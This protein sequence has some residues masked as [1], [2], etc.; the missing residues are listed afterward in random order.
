MIIDSEVE[1]DNETLPSLSNQ[2]N[3]PAMNGNKT[4]L[5]EFGDVNIRIS[6]CEEQLKMLK[7]QKLNIQAKLLNA[8][9]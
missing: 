1:D 7:E 8:M 3:E 5:N 2:S 6:K 4:L 9:K